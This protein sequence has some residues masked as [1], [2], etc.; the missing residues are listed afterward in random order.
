MEA[1]LQAP[2]NSA[3][4]A[5]DHFAPHYDAFTSHHDYELWLGNVLP[6]AEALGLR[7]GSLLDVAC[8]TGKSF[9]PMLARGW[10]VTACDVSAEMVRRAA[11]KAPAEVRLAVA[12]MRALPSLG[13]FDLVSCFGDAVNYLR[14]VDELVSALRGFRANLAPDGLAIFDVNTLASYRGL[15]AETHVVRSGLVTLR[16]E[17]H[18]ST[19]FGPGEVAEATVEAR[20]P[21]GRSTAAVHRQRHFPLDELLAALAEAELRPLALYGHGFDAK[22]ERPLDESRHTK[23]VVIACQSKEER[24]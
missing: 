7:V 21:S 8:G 13:G 22:L 18:A 23:A 5:Y 17:G 14:D 6:A 15:F 24:R 3:E 1:E 19:S 11:A 20:D 4:A 9:L 12:D 10:R 2:K 16:W